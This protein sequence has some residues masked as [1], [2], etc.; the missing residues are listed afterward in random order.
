MYSLTVVHY[1]IITRVYKKYFYF[2]LI[3]FILFCLTITLCI[4][5]YLLVIIKL[6]IE[7]YFRNLF[8]E[9]HFSDGA[10]W[11]LAILL[12][13]TGFHN[14]LTDGFDSEIIV[15]ADFVP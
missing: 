1:K 13:E 3:A 7:N 9:F 8:E 10:H 12:D 15:K 14:D 4:Y 11:I 5:I 6:F 2:F